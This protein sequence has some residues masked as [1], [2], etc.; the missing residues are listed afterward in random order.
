MSRTKRQVGSRRFP[1]WSDSEAVQSPSSDETEDNSLKKAG[2]SSTPRS[3]S[4]KHSGRTGINYHP[5]SYNVGTKLGTYNGSTCLETFFAKFDNCAQNFRWNSED[6]LFHLRGSLEGPAGEV[7]RAAGKH[8]SVKELVKLLRNQ[9]RNESQAE[10]FPAELRARRRRPGES[11]QSLYI[12]ICRLMALPYPGPPSDLSKI[13]ARDAFLEALNE[14]SLRV[15]ILEREPTTLDAALNIAFRLE[16]FDKGNAENSERLDVGNKYRDKYI[17]TA[18]G[19]DGKT[20]S[21]NSS[22]E[23]N[24]KI[25]AQLSELLSG[26]EFCKSELLQQRKELDNVCCQ[27][28]QARNVDR[29]V[30]WFNGRGDACFFRFVWVRCWR[31]SWAIYTECAVWASIELC[32]GK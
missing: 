8:T 24:G 16:A 26:V 4:R 1:V 21:S 19:A 20:N 31:V 7:L 10:R 28:Q 9:F 18:T 2:R 11:I 17:K 23:V 30:A 12:D 13:V 6:R 14:K 32:W 29:N 3:Y 25:S 15:R 5:S 27:Q 22:S